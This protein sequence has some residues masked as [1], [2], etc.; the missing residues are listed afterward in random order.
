MTAGAS[1]LI[2]CRGLRPSCLNGRHCRFDSGTAAGKK[3]YPG[4]MSGV[5][6][7]MA[8]KASSQIRNRQLA[9][10]LIQAF[11]QPHP[12]KEVKQQWVER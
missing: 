11:C 2:S 5:F 9:R 4:R 1:G 10:Q 3:R 8:E 6:D 7:F 12:F